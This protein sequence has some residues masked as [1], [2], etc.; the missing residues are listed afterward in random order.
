MPGHNIPPLLLWEDPYT[1]T[2]IFLPPFLLLLATTQFSLISV[3]SWFALATLFAVGAIKTYTYVMVNL[4]NKLPAEPSSDPLTPVYGI[5]MTVPAEKVAGLSHNITDLLNS[6]LGEL[7]RLFLAESIIDTIKFG[8]SLYCLTYI[9]SWFN[10]LTIIIFLWSSLFIF[11]MAYIYNQET[12]DDI[13][14]KAGAQ[15]TEIQI[16]KVAS[17]LPKKKSE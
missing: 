12:F 3:L 8:A 13:V 1:T 11:P 14:E 16:I 4:L 9:G 6:F 5:S 10:M 17:F 7:R 15:I 2:P